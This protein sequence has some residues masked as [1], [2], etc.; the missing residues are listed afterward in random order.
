MDIDIIVELRPDH[1]RPL[2]AEFPAPGFYVSE[3]AAAEAVRLHRPF[4]VVHPQS[5]GKIDFMVLPETDWARL[6][7]DRRRRVDF[8]PGCSGYVAAPEDVILGKLVYHHGG[9]SDKHLRDIRSVLGI[10]GDDLD[11]AY[12]AEQAVALGVAELWKQIT[13]EGQS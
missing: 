8:S 2:C 3:E 5:G 7:L 12:I 1:V 11:C 6:Q 4:N 9:G 13:G 10:V